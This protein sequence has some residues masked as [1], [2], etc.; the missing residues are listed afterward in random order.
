MSRE[1]KIGILAV[2]CIAGLIWGYKFLK[3]KNILSR[4]D[5]FYVVFEKVEDLPI[6]APVLISGLQIGT[7]QNQYLLDGNPNAI[8][9]VLD[10]KKGLKV[11]KDAVVVMQSTSLMG[12][13]SI[14]LQYSGPCSNNCAVS[15]DTLAG[16]HEG[17]LSTL[18]P[19]ETLNQ[20]LESIRENVGGI[21]DSLDSKLMSDSSDAGRMV[22]D[23]KATIENL[24]AISERLNYVLTAT[25]SNIVKVG[26]D[27]QKL[28]STIAGS[29][30][31]LNNIISNTES[32]S[33]ELSGAEIG[34]T[35]KEAGDAVKILDE[36]LMSLK[37]GSAELEVVM[38]K[39]NNGDGSLGKLMNDKALYDN[40]ERSTRQ[41]DLLLQDLRLNPKRYVHISVF[42]KKQKDYTLPD[43]DPAYQTEDA[44][45]LK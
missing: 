43:E 19:T 22:Q 12:G 25:S 39:I 5:T 27:L 14:R 35:L 10:I 8:L 7:V 21:V 11:P 9:V 24:R 40:M 6:S 26:N 2:L 41:L 3:G 33:S 30:E 20:Y 1:T 28:S 42:G 34:K 36:T 32:V 4:S 18:L 13:K 16:R 31:K 29:S 17:I 38:S 37:R 45:K 44:D 23:V 15:G